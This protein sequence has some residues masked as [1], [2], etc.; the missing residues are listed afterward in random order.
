MSV[1]T[2]VG[3]R[4]VPRFL[5]TY[6]PTQIYDALDVVDNG[7]GTSYI[8]RKT[9]PAGTPL[10]DTDHWFVYGASSGAIIALQNDMIQAQ[11]DILGLQSD[12]ADIDIRTD[13]TKMRVAA[14]TDS[15]GTSAADGT[16]FTDQIG[17]RLGLSSADYFGFARGSVGV[18]PNSVQPRGVQ[19][20]VEDS[21][22]SITDPDTITHVLYALGANDIANLTGIDTAFASLVTYTRSQ[23]PNAEIFFAFIGNNNGA[24]IANKNAAVESYK[25]NA[26]INKCK[27]IKNT[28][29][30]LRL[31]PYRKSDG[32]ATSDGSDALAEAMAFGLLNGYCV[33]QMSGT[34]HGTFSG[35][36]IGVNYRVDDETLTL[37]APPVTLANPVNLGASWVQMPISDVI[38]IDGAGVYTGLILCS[39][40]GVYGGMTGTFVINNGDIY[41]KSAGALF[42][43]QTLEI[44]TYNVNIRDLG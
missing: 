22:A 5:G 28:D 29:L 12:V 17:T 42:T 11:N 16:P 19:G 4:Y 40:T 41:L 27:F 25:E 6:D 31:K 10:T 24:T 32:H 13:I 36:T 21:I 39:G 7:S 1:H 15:N 37:N 26:S 14:F 44:P 3:A 9:V 38:P 20:L 43:P 2:Y 35:S 23:F 18:N 34:F 33:V 30:I 8:A